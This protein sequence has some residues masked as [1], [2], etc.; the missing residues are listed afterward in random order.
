MIRDGVQGT[1]ASGPSLVKGLNRFANI[2]EAARNYNSGC[3]NEKNMNDG[4]SS[5]E[6]YVV[7]IANRM[8]GWVLANR[9]YNCLSYANGGA[10]D[11]TAS[12]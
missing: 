1:G 7:D 9:N 2:Y 4:I 3:V 5:T 10:G 11:C 6:T 8:T 12:A